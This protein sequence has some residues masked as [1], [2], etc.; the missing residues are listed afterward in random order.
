MP[1]DDDL[2]HAMA[3][4]MT[5]FAETIA[6]LTDT[7]LDAASM[8]DGW[9]VRDVVE[10]IIGGDR[11]AAFVL[12]GGSLHDAIGA[13]MGVDHLGDD[14][15]ASVADA[16]AGARA[17]FTRSLD[18][19]VEH[20]V[21]VIPARRFISFRV[22]DQLGHTWDIAEALDREVA[23]DPEAV[24]VALEIVDLE[25]DMLDASEHFAMPPAIDADDT[26][27]QVT[28]LRSIGRG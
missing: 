28:F 20:P 9:T 3:A 17:G 8:C 1:S 14:M 23:L 12:D 13:V 2:R 15:M 5:G 7:D 25:R 19:I 26:D 16:S 21:G 11:F 27:P 18:R 10:H 6:T 24:R 4:A 22:L